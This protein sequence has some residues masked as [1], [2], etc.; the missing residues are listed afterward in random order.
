MYVYLSRYLYKQL[1]QI[2]DS[3]TSQ[4]G[5][6]VA[7][8]IRM[9]DTVLRNKH[10][11]RMSPLEKP[12]PTMDEQDVPSNSFHRSALHPNGVLNSEKNKWPKSPLDAKRDKAL[13]KM[14]WSIA[15]DPGRRN[16]AQAYEFIWSEIPGKQQCNICD[17]GNF[18]EMVS[19]E[20]IETQITE[21][22]AETRLEE[23][24]AIRLFV[25]GLHWDSSTD[26]T[27]LSLSR[28]AFEEV[29]KEFDLHPATV[30]AIQRYQYASLESSSTVQT[31][32][33]SSAGSVSL[34]AF[35]EPMDS[36]E[37]TF[38]SL[39]YSRER[40]HTDAVLFTNRQF[41]KR[42]RDDFIRPLVD[43]LR[44]LPEAWKHLRLLP[45]VC[46]QIW[47]ESAVTDLCCLENDI[48]AV[49]RSLGASRRWEGECIT[50]QNW[51]QNVEVN[52]NTA[53]LHRYLYTIAIHRINMRVA[54]HF[55]DL[56]AELETQTRATKKGTYP[57]TARLGVEVDLEHYCDWTSALLRLAEIQIETLGERAQVQANL[58]FSI[59][60]QK[61]NHDSISMAQSAFVFT[62]ITALFLPCTFVASLFSMSMFDWQTDSDSNSTT[63]TYVSGRFWIYWATSLPLTI[64]VMGGWYWWSVKG[65]KMWNRSDSAANED[66]TGWRAKSRWVRFLGRAPK[67]TQ[68]VESVQSVRSGHSQ[69]PLGS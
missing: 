68:H 66:A 61:D 37:H 69:E 22:I 64:L 38:M 1:H 27:G 11:H 3:V 34:L 23:T 12:S 31:E 36:G 14:Y 18:E 50:S 8:L 17:F 5:R 54:K 43:G 56:L 51:P 52:R 24:I 60:S 59:I 44:G 20:S 47:V 46:L 39:N 25:C 6:I 2:W 62:F 40:K 21:W 10:P 53:E 41:A 33:S 67:P 32:Y 19:D 45:E 16:H 55:H 26:E 57:F 29:E 63:H 15:A 42:D 4:C 65:M 7:R 9:H 49:E 13:D 58:L 35:F 30:S 28:K 48:V